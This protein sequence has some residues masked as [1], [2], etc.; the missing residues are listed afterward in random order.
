MQANFLVK[1]LKSNNLP[2]PPQQVKKLK[3]KSPE[4]GIFFWEE[5]GKTR[6]CKNIE[7]IYTFLFKCYNMD[8]NYETKS[9]SKIYDRRVDTLYTQ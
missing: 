8:I 1:F 3:R 6:M 7:D 4:R 9:N 2:H 5:Y